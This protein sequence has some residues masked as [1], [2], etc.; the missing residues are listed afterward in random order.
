ME[1]TL[2]AIQGKAA[3]LTEIAT[4][5]L[6]AYVRERTNSTGDGDLDLPSRDLELLAAV[7]LDLEALK[8]E[9]SAEREQFAQ[10]AAAFATAPPPDYIVAGPVRRS[11]LGNNAADYVEVAAIPAWLILLAIES[12]Q[13]TPPA[14]AAAGRANSQ[15]GEMDVYQ[16]DSGEGGS[17]GWEASPTTEA[18]VSSLTFAFTPLFTGNLYIAPKVDYQGTIV[19][20]SLG[21]WYTES[22]ADLRLD[23]QCSVH[24]AFTDEGPVLTLVH[25]HK[26]HRS[27]ARYWI[28]GSA[29]PIASTK[30][31]A[32]RPVLITVSAAISAFAR[33]DHAY[34]EGDFKNGANHFIRVP[35][36]DLFNAPF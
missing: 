26:D 34:A 9:A 16:Q 33:S 14:I 27:S 36:I 18:D 20:F 5:R 17:W 11:V 6:A 15:L 25:E 32:G 13:I 29:S 28:S 24:Q 30:V 4:A 35:S 7:G 22:W 8:E 12:S 19:I 23:F 21:H 2:G 10:M 31:V 3:D 1:T